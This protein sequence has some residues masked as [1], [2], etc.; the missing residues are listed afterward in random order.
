MAAL[1][2]AVA[3]AVRMSLRL[4]WRS[5]HLTAK[6]SWPLLSARLRSHIHVRA[7]VAPVVADSAR[8]CSASGR[9]APDHVAAG[10]PRWRVRLVLDAQPFIC[11]SSNLSIPAGDLLNAS[12]LAAA[13]PSMQNQML[14]EELFPAIARLQPAF[15]GKHTGRTLVL[16][17][18]EIL[19]ILES[20]Q[21]L[22][23]LV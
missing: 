19:T 17:N 6:T 9:A 18:S 8:A 16:A 7:C 4:L 15:S 3:L 11:A 13:P 21:Q 20:E 23:D 10:A 2:L 5:V 22:A 12:A 14:G 1:H